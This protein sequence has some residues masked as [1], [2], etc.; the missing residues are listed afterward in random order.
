MRKKF[1]KFPIFQIKN[2][3]GKFV[4]LLTKKRVRL[5]PQISRNSESYLIVIWKS[6]PKFRT[7]AWFVGSLKTAVK[8]G[9]EDD[10]DIATLHEG[11]I[12]LVGDMAKLLIGCCCWMSINRKSISSSSNVDW[13]FLAPEFGS[14]E[15]PPIRKF[16]VLKHK[17]N[18]QLL[19][20]AHSNIG[21]RSVNLIWNIRN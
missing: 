13:E 11:D 6:H 2:G 12:A 8:D 17:F 1:Q 19:D 4:Y 15:G 5:G 20:L 9:A 18:K 21:D 16:G 7:V 3:K 10:G 14:D